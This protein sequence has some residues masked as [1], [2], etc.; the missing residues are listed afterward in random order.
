MLKMLPVTCSNKISSHDVVLHLSKGTFSSVRCNIIWNINSR[1]NP[2]F[3]CC[4]NKNS[5]RWCWQSSH[6][7]S[8][9]MKL[10]TKWEQKRCREP[11]WQMLFLSK[12]WRDLWGGGVEWWAGGW[13]WGG[14]LH[15]IAPV[16]PDSRR[17]CVSNVNNRAAQDRITTHVE[18][19]GSGQWATLQNWT[20]VV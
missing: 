10:K 18:L 2:H 20:E 11:V 15:T 5:L 12:I 4:S 17:L 14:L 7:H 16:S 3:L 9:G 13:T 19:L 6:R 8:L 1:V